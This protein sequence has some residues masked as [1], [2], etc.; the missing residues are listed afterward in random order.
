MTEFR[1][2]GKSR[3]DFFKGGMYPLCDTC[4]F[5]AVQ[6]PNPS[7]DWTEAQ[8]L[9]EILYRAAMISYSLTATRYKQNEDT[10]AWNELVMHLQ[11]LLAG[12][13][14]PASIIEPKNDD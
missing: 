2:W 6:H 11:R 7:H 10:K 3:E 12:L 1:F 13:H 9:R 14:T 5:P 8:V 4:D